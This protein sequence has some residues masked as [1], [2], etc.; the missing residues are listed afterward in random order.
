MQDSHIELIS[1][2]ME[3]CLALFDKEETPENCK[4]LQSLIEAIGIYICS[5]I[6]IHWIIPNTG[7]EKSYNVILPALA[8]M[9]S[10]AKFFKISINSCPKAICGTNFKTES[11]DNIV[12]TPP[13]LCAIRSHAPFLATTVLTN[14]HFKDHAVSHPQNHRA[15]VKHCLDIAK[16][17]YAK[18]RSTAEIEILEMLKN[19]LS[20]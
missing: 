9:C 18:P 2:S 5:P 20:I 19:E 3:G 11:D 1:R 14:L 8:I 16:I 4:K 7:I 10:K 15:H 12:L 17:Y 6:K 13:L